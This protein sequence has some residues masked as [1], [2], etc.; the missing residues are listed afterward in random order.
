MEIHKN[1]RKINN[2]QGSGAQIRPQIGPKMAPKTAQEAPK[3]AQEAPKTAK[4]PPKTPQE[5]PRTAQEAPKTAQEAPRR[6]QDAPRGPPRHR[7]R[8]GIGIGGA[9]WAPRARRGGGRGRGK[10]SKD[11]AQ[12]LNTP[13]GRRP[14]EF[15]RCGV[16]VTSVGHRTNGTLPH[17]WGS[18]VQLIRE[19]LV[20]IGIHGPLGGGTHWVP[21]RC[22]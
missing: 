5:A 6:P 10:T 11:I 9:S 2:F 4:E 18:R 14:G 20:W 13:L 3:T 1:P 12:D 16:A 19:R 15:L 7:Q 8:R 22:H 17:V 21:R